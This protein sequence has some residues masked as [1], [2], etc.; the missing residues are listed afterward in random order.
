MVTTA[1]CIVARR[2]GQ[3]VIDGLLVN[4]VA[5]SEAVTTLGATACEHLA[6]ILG[7]HTSTEA[8]LVSLLKVRGLEC[9]FHFLSKNLIC[10]LSC[11][12]SGAKLLLIF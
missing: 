12:K 7:L 3:D 4:A 8:V 1:C 6:T 11:E 2:C 5:D 10:F 9:T